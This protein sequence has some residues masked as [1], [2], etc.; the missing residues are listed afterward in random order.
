MRK[1]SV[2]LVGLGALFLVLAVVYGYL[3]N[4][5]L[6]LAQFWGGK[7]TFA[8]TKTGET[9]LFAFLAV[10]LPLLAVP[11]AVLSQRQER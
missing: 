8:P 4:T 5:W 1:A 9:V 2:V 3:F 6:E 7:A 10:A 11:L